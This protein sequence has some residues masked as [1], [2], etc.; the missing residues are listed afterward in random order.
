MKNKKG[1]TLIELL[2]VIVILAIIALIAVPIVLNMIN[3]AKKGAAVSSAYGYIE[4]IEN[5]Q[6][7]AQINSNEILKEGHYNVATKTDLKDSEGNVIKSVSK[8]NSLVKMKG[9]KPSAGT[10]DIA[11]NQQVS[12]ATLCINGFV[13]RYL[14]QKSEVI[15]DDCGD[16]DLITD[17]AVEKE[18]WQTERKLTINYPE[19]NY[20]YYYKVS[21]K[22]KVNDA[23]IETNK[24][25]EATNPQVL[26]L[27]ENQTVETWIIKNGKKIAI[28]TYVE[29]MIDNVEVIE[30]EATATS[31]YP[32]L[33][34]YG[35]KKDIKLDITNY[36]SQKGTHAEY[37][38]DNGTT[39][40][41]Y[42]SVTT[43]KALTIKVK[44]VR[45]E[46]K[47]ESNIKNVEISGNE[48][49]DALGSNAYDN[50]I[51]TSVIT[52]YNFGIQPL[53]IGV[54]SSMIGE[55]VIVTLRGYGL[56][57]LLDK[58]NKELASESISQSTTVK[59]KQKI[60]I[61][62]GTSKIMFKSASSGS[63][64]TIFEVEVDTAPTLNATFFNPKIYSDKIKNGYKKVEILPFAEGNKILYKIN[65]SEW[66]EYKN[67]VD[68]EL[69]S[70]IYA[71]S[72]LNNGNESMKSI[73]KVEDS[74]ALPY[75]AIDGDKTTSVITTYNFGIQPF[76]ID[77]DSSMIGRNVI[78]TLR[79]FGYI[80][81]L[82]KDNKEL[83][84]EYISQSTTAK[85]EQKINIVEGTSKIMFKSA[86]SGSHLKI[87]EVEI[88]N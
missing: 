33:S 3:N 69:E 11:S 7:L 9:K 31:G 17:L 37:S 55:N 42:T 18:G 19:G 66:L 5:Y 47:R 6:A 70:T 14:N 58:D 39:W 32:I 65:S 72:I 71:K 57:T 26:M 76:Y 84:S 29:N 10:I 78:V 75:K 54:D 51:N 24:E 64:L 61:V 16:M 35:F 12:G 52:T 83:A 73:L 41:K 87:F 34:K 36:N 74:H 8:I 22:A 30:P 46:S 56:I 40:K 38:T 80:I 81:L 48:I 49:K 67:K 44:M 13:V 82:D 15:A 86:S 4:S 20:K 1:F 62:D 45:D 25:L 27:E 59:L 88:G 50:D 2:A 43:I 60:N 23:L 79:G 28:T 68:V 21:G 77:V 53:Y 63:H 85:L